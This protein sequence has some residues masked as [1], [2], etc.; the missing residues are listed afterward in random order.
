MPAGSGGVP[1]SAVRFGSKRR[2]IKGSG[3]LAGRPA[4]WMSGDEEK[5]YEKLQSA[6]DRVRA[7]FEKLHAMHEAT[8]LEYVAW[9]YLKAYGELMVRMEAEAIRMVQALESN[10]AEVKRLTEQQNFFENLAEQQMRELAE[11]NEILA[12][13]MGLAGAAP[14]ALWPAYEKSVDP[15]SASDVELQSVLE[16]HR[17]RHGASSI[18]ALVAASGVAAV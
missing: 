17:A 1:R 11:S 3:R 10:I 6:H 7:D 14:S 9:P 15:G 13:V 2:R 4:A 12:R 16:W 18:K 8:K 5:R